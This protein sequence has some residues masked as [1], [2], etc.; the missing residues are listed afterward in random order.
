[1]QKSNIAVTL[2]IDDQNEIFVCLSLMFSETASNSLYVIITRILTCI[3]VYFIRKIT[4]KND[5]FL[6]S[7]RPYF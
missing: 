2:V 7:I 1:M 4:L 5:F 3:F 6:V